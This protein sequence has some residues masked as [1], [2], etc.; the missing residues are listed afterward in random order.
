MKSDEELV[1]KTLT[2]GNQHYE[3]LVNRYADYLFGLGMRLT[4]GNRHIAEDIAQQTF[5][6]AY[7]YL[8]KF[9]CNKNFKHWLTGIAVNCF[10]DL[11]SSENKTQPLQ[12]YHNT[13]YTPDFEANHDF[14]V[15]IQPLNK[16]ERLIFTLKFVY[17]YNLK[18]ISEL[19]N[20]K[21]GTLKSRVS[22]SLNKLK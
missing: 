1:S 21:I 16:E 7:F 2:D 9:D 5:M 8:G 3:V 12:E 11:A 4:C 15:M 22:R 14:F 13:T 18:E 17:D 10:K 20:I 6:R 19:L